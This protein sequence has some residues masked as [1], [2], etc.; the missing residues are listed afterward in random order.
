MDIT[1]QK[2]SR[3]QLL[4]VAENRDE[5]VARG[6]QFNA[7]L[8]LFSMLWKYRTAVHPSHFFFF[9]LLAP[10]LANEEESSLS[11]RRCPDN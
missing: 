10:R 2:V 1:F 4:H 9:A 8:Q 6:R 7:N 3:E 11:Y 5:W